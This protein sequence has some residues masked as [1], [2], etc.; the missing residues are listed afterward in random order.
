MHSDKYYADI[1]ARI[2]NGTLSYSPDTAAAIHAHARIM[3][4]IEMSALL[5]RAARSLG[6]R[7]AALFN[8]TPDVARANA[9]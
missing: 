6:S 5:G 3:R 8:K 7:L 2:A 4:S 9:R 1:Q